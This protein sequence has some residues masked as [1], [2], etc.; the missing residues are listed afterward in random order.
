[1]RSCQAEFLA[2]LIAS[3][4]LFLASLYRRSLT[5]TR[6][7]SLPRLER[8][9]I[10]DLRDATHSRRNTSIFSDHQCL[11][12]VCPARD[13][14]TAIERSQA[15]ETTLVIQPAYSS[16]EQSG[17]SSS[18]MLKGHACAEK[19]I[20]SLNSASSIFRM[21]QRLIS[22]PVGRETGGRDGAMLIDINTWSDKVS[23][24]SRIAQPRNEPVSTGE[25]QIRSTTDSPCGL[26]QV[27]RPPALA[28]TKPSEENKR[29]RRSPLLLP[30]GEP[31]NADLALKSPQTRILS[32][33]R[34][35]IADSSVHECSG[36]KG[37][38]NVWRNVTV[39]KRKVAT[40]NRHVMP[41]S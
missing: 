18:L 38:G 34:P 28:K 5:R 15:S 41:A 2:L 6:S 37:E 20:A 11:L 39:E 8:C 33:G 19:S 3:R 14:I 24:S 16:G 1:M 4:S 21:F 29:R 31:Q 32:T 25:I 22:Q 35:L 12:R 13:F 9:R 40:Q 10:H 23:T 36:E 30:T 17:F 27:G 7:Q 26:I